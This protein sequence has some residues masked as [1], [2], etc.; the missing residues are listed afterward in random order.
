[1]KNYQMNELVVFHF[2]LKENFIHYKILCFHLETFL[3][4][5]NV[6]ENQ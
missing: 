6:N 5:L 4:S 3:H 2:Q 1:M